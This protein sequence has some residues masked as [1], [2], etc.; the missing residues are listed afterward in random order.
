M[1]KFSDEELH[2]LFDEAAKRNDEGMQALIMTMG[3]IRSQN[4]ENAETELIGLLRMFSGYLVTKNTVQGGGE[5]EPTVEH[6]P[7]YNL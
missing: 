6:S 3:M 4:D 5:H 7:V 2:R 1:N